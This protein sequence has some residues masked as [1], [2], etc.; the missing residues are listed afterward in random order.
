MKL[1]LFNPSQE[2]DGWQSPHTVVAMLNNDMPFIIDLV[3]AYLTAQHLSIHR[4][5]HPRPLDMTRT[6]AEFGAG[7]RELED[8]IEA[9]LSPSGLANLGARQTKFS[10]NGVP[11]SLPVLWHP[12]MP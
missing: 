3:T 1:R 9:F 8:K 4:L 7:I 6:I 5:I 2:V 12:S 11:I 10:Q